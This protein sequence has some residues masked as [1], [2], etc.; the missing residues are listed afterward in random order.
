M[1]DPQKDFSIPLFFGEGE[2]LPQIITSLQ[3]SVK[4]FEFNTK[5][6]DC[7]IDR[8]INKKNSAK[9]TI[10]CS[11]VFLHFMLAF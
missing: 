3:D 4:D 9:K 5:N 1:Q 10:L 6:A 7:C 8:K 11:V 2:P